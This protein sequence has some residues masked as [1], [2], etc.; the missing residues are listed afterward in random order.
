MQEDV[1]SLEFCSTRLEWWTGFQEEQNSSLPS[2]SFR[3]SN[4]VRASYPQSVVL[5]PMMA[6]QDL[7]R[8]G[9][10]SG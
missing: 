5:G 6:V 9:E 2:P 7:R 4:P 3:M 1:N 10:V 8:M